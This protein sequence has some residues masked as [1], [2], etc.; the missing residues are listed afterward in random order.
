MGCAAGVQALRVQDSAL[1]ATALAADNLAMAVYFVGLSLIAASSKRKKAGEQSPRV[2]NSSRE[3][4]VSATGTPELAAAHAPAPVT[5]AELAVQ[6]PPAREHDAATQPGAAQDGTGPRFAGACVRVATAA[7][8]VSSGGV[9]AG[10]VGWPGGGLFVMAVLAVAVASVGAAAQRRVA[11]AR[12]LPEGGA[13]QNA[14][15]LSRRCHATSDT[16]LNDLQ[17]LIGLC[18]TKLQL[19]SPAGL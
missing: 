3:S 19:Q 1:V 2:P 9:I 8:C 18:A 11:W 13:R 15:C 10:R 6:I 5:T 16:R 7:A 12:P 4:A 14:L 17:L